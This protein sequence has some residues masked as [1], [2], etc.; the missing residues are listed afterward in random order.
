MY[1]HRISQPCKTWYVAD[2]A[3]KRLHRQRSKCGIRKATRQ[4]LTPTIYSQVRGTSPSCF[5]VV[6][7][8]S[9]TTAGASFYSG[10]DERP[11]DCLTHPRRR[12]TLRRSLEVARRRWAGSGWQLTFPSKAL[13]RESILPGSNPSVS[14]QP[15]IVQYRSK[16]PPAPGSHLPSYLQ[17]L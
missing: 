8:S 17:A 3:K 5:F 6:Q 2:N 11:P 1:C 14:S 9:S 4:L 16:P 10:W 13:S 12:A 15:A 7:V